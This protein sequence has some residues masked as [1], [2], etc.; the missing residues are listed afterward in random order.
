MT[1]SPVL[2][3]VHVAR[4]PHDCFDL[5]TSRV[6]AWWP[7]RTHGLFHDRS[8]GV[9]FE[10]DR[11]VER[12][13]DGEE[14]VWGR[15]V[16]WEPGRRL[17]LTWHPGRPDDGATLVEVH[18]LPVEDG[19]RVE[20]VH[21]GWE[22]LGDGGPER[23][24]YAGPNAWGW[25]LEHFADTAERRLATGDLPDTA[26]LRAASGAFVALARGGGF[27]PPADDGWTHLQVVAH[28][29]LTSG[30]LAAVCRT[31]LTGGEPV[32][33]NALVE[34]RASLD[35]LVAAHDGDLGALVDAAERAG[36][37]LVRL[38]ERLDPE[39]LATK[40]PARIVD[41]GEV[42]LDEPVPWGRLAVDVQAARHLPAHTAQL[43]AL[44][45]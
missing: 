2:R 13:L 16:T 34:R 37:E 29:A 3:A 22:T 31:L 1:R 33:D 9:A 19:T 45:A 15:V 44:R 28:V 12:S 4:T 43:A 38:V 10:G 36:D 14:A 18:F 42:V 27:G 25:V 17:A 32:F 40:V 11:L 23:R 30:A 5:F 35:A 6:G 21:S 39:H 26:A 41:G 8:A 7:L 20:L 24:S